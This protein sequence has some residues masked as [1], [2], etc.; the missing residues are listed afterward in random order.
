MT[1]SKTFKKP[2]SRPEEFETHEKTKPI[3]VYIVVVEKEIEKFETK[4][5]VYLNLGYQLIGGVTTYFDSS[6]GVLYY[7]QSVSK[8]VS[9][10]P[11]KEDAN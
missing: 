4:V 11:E 3:Y 9:P 10:R 5:S 7:L 1:K 2:E 8:E 6:Q